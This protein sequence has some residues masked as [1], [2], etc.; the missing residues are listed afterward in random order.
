MTPG[1]QEAR[2]YG[3]LDLG[4]VAERDALTIAQKMLLG[5]VQL[6]QLRAKNM[7]RR[8]YVLSRATWRRCAALIGFPAS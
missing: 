1:L 4:Y 7:R 5:G 8:R 6:L 2:L 3:I